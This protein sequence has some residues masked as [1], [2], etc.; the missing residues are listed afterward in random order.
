MTQKLSLSLQDLH[1]AIDS[2]GGWVLEQFIRMRDA[3]MFSVGWTGMLRCS[4]LVGLKWEHVRF[5]S[6]GE[7]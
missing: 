2:M 7:G 6:D 5:S 3:A 1:K 4:E